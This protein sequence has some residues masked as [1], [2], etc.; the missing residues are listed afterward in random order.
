MKYRIWNMDTYDT[1]RTRLS[2]REDAYVVPVHNA[3]DLV[4]E[5]RKEGR[6]EGRTK[7]HTP[8]YNRWLWPTATAVT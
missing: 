7:I 1:Y 5:G 8:E 4:F 2:V 3:Y 6:K